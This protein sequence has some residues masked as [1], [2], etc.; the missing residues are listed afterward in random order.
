MLP[1]DAR[2][3]LLAALPDIYRVP[4]T[5]PESTSRGITIAPDIRWQYQSIP[6]PS[7]PYD[8][9]ALDLSPTG[10]V[11]SSQ[12]IDQV[13]GI[14]VAD[15]DATTLSDADTAE[16]KGRRVYDELNIR[17]TSE[18]SATIG[19]RSFSAGERA[20]GLAR[21]LVHFLLNE[22]QSRPVD[23]FTDDGALI[24]DDAQYYA[25]EF[26]PPLRIEP[27][28]GRGPTRVTD[29]V[30]AAGEQWDAAVR[31]HYFDGWVEWFYE[32]TAAEINHTFDLIGGL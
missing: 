20:N 5:L 31:L 8:Q 16:V 22:F 11:E 12:S 9:I 7:P 10:V 19:G 21:E 32:A 14:V 29:M 3:D 4:A 27:V 26:A 30:D 18:G 13:I 17:V 23:P 1:L 28:S 24:T 2:R 15:P 25:E 6:Q